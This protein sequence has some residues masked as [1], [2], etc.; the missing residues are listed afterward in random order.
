MRIQQLPS[1]L[2][3]LAMC[4]SHRQLGES[5]IVDPASKCVLLELQE[6]DNQTCQGLTGRG[7]VLDILSG[8]ETKMRVCTQMYGKDTEKEKHLAIQVILHN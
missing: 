8:G 1:V 3:L 6:L 5:R 2:F 4:V 7:V